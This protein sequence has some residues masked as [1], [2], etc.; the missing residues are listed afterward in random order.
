MKQ[1]TELEL[2][3]T[4]TLLLLIDKIIIGETQKI[5]GRRV[6]EIQILNN[7]VGDIDKLR[8]D[9]VLADHKGMAFSDTMP[10]A[11]LKRHRIA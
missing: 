8:L 11:M 4:E 6:C 10:F 3:D 2:F 9:S 7:Y 1:Y 5:G